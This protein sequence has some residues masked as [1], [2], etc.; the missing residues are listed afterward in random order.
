MLLS[1]EELDLQDITL[2]VHDFGGPIALPI[3]LEQPGAGEPAD[4]DE[5]V[6]VELRGRPSR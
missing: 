5:L 3:A 2:V 4:S 6:D 1:I